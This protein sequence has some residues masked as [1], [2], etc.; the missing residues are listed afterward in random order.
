MKHQHKL[1]NKTVDTYFGV[2]Y[3]ET[4][5]LTD[6]NYT[7]EIDPM[8]DLIEDEEHEDLMEEEGN[9]TIGNLLAKIKELEK[10]IKIAKQEKRKEDIQTYTTNIGQGDITVRSRV[11]KN[12]QQIEL[13]NQNDEN[14]FIFKT[15]KYKFDADKKQLWLNTIRMMKRAVEGLEVRS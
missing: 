1:V 11:S 10:E 8:D 2:I 5:V 13:L 4:C 12:G 3:F 9:E 7:K 15:E 14:E 6:C